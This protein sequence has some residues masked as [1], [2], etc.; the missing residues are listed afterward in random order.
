[1]FACAVS[2]RRQSRLDLSAGLNEVRWHSPVLYGSHLRELVSVRLSGALTVLCDSRDPTKWS[3]YTTPLRA[4]VQSAEERFNAMVDIVR[5]YVVAVP[6]VTSCSPSMVAPVQRRPSP[7]DVAAC[8]GHIRE[9]TAAT[10]HLGEA[11]VRTQVSFPDK[12]LVQYDCGK[13]QVG[14]SMVASGSALWW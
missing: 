6:R 14:A 3:T 10:A 2:L 11:T 7:V 8:A 13:L 5:H 12:W 1:M 4:A 9:Y